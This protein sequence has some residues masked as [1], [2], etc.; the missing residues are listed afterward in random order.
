MG[1]WCQQSPRQW[2]WQP[3][4]SPLSDHNAGNMALC[5]CC[6]YIFICNTLV[7]I[8][9]I[10]SETV[11]M[12]ADQLPL[13]ISNP[14]LTQHF[15]LTLAGSGFHSSGQ[16][17]NMKWAKFDRCTK[18]F[19]TITNCV[20]IIITDEFD[21][22]AGNPMLNHLVNSVTLFCNSWYDI[23]SC[24]FMWFVYPYPSGFLHWH[25]V[26]HMITP[27]PTKEPW[28]IWVKTTMTKPQQNMTKQIICIILI[29]GICVDCFTFWPSLLAQT[30]I[31]TLPC[32]MAIW[33][34]ELTAP[35]I[36]INHEVSW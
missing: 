10:V 21:W 34:A 20:N 4:M 11:Y 25:R 12:Q 26:N 9:I 29:L 13:M 24:R 33:L 1:H 17:F 16:N 7:L 2:V 14:K 15:L 6:F 18:M 32:L 22:S 5:L 8:S 23:F 19:I 36:Y 30:L 27:M 35:Y 28:R 3:S 31:H